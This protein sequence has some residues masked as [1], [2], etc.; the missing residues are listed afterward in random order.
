MARRGHESPEVVQ[1]A[2]INMKPTWRLVRLVLRV[3]HRCCSV[4]VA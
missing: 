1:Q 3:H 4:P 2:I